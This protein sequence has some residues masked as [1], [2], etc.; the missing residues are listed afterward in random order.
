MAKVKIKWNL[1][2]FA[3]IRTLPAAMDLVYE[4]ADRIAYACGDGFVAEATETPTRARAA[5]IAV[6]PKA[7]R[8]DAKRNVILSNVE[9]GRI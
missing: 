5:V 3:E 9:W 7:R 1:P 2:A 4:S 8:Q 6:S